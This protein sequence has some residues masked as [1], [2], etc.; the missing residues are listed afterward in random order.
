MADERNG[1]GG[2]GAGMMRDADLEI[3]NDEIMQWSETGRQRYANLS[4]SSSGGKRKYRRRQVKP[5]Y[6]NDGEE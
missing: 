1:T 6:S 2:G 5:V 3:A 4:G